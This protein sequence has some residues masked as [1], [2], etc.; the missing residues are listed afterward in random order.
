[1]SSAD[2]AGTFESFKGAVQYVDVV[3]S[4]KK[5]VGFGCDGA[6]VNIAAN[7]S[8]GFLSPWVVCFW[9]LAHSLQLDI[10]KMLFLL[11]Y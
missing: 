4:E 2:A 5:L 9:C 7:G 3:D 6:S 1:M 8:R 10:L 11:C